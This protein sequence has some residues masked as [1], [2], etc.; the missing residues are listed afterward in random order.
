M[1]NIKNNYIKAGIA[2]R[3]SINLQFLPQARAI[4]LDIS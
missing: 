3:P 4:P 1:K 2:A